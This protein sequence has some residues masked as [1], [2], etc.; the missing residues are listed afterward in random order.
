M[1]FVRFFAF[2]CGSFEWIVDWYQNTGRTAGTCRSG[3]K[4]LNW[5]QNYAA[6]GDLTAETPRAML[7]AGRSCLAQLWR[8]HRL[9]IIAPPAFGAF[10]GG[11]GG[12]ETLAR[13]S[14]PKE[15]LIRSFGLYLAL[16][17]RGGCSCGY[18]RKTMKQT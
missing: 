9:P 17:P 5:Y 16:T 8:D 7:V 11:G 15:G 2:A 3:G 6:P 4:S 13:L 10:R 18:E 12:Q 14:G 1:T